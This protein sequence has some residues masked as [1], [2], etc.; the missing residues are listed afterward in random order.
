M[1]TLNYGKLANLRAAQSEDEVGVGIGTGT[2]A[3]VASGVPVGDARE[4]GETRQTNAAP[5]WPIA[6]VVFSL[7]LFLLCL[8][9]L[10]LF[11]VVVAVMF[12]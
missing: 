7:L 5:F 2:G 12:T 10:L 11:L 3:G 8:L 1:L 9:L 4:A 6:I